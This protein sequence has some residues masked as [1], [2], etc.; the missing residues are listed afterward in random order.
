VAPAI[1]RTEPGA[2]PGRRRIV[3]TTFGSL[4]D[5]QPHIAV[6][7]G[8]QARGQEAVLATG[9]YYGRE[10]EALGIGLRA[11]RPDHPDLGADADLMRRILG[12]RKGSGCVLREFMMPVLRGPYE[13][14]RAA[15]AGASPLVPHVLTFTTRLVAEQQGTPWAPTSLQPLG[16]FPVYGPPVLPQA[17]FL[18]KPR[19]LGPAFR[20]PLCWCA[21]RGVRS[22]S[23]R[24][25]MS[26]R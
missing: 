10:V 2:S 26:D 20:R 13:D 4:G 14:T 8:L 19:S 5:L 16:L 1:Q 22:W 7:L 11:V 17:P 25:R 23:E 15:A 3:L 12:R 24:D 9:S 6:A 21:K 18:S